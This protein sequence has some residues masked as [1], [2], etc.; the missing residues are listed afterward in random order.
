MPAVAKVTHNIRMLILD[1]QPKDKEKEKEIT[2][3]QP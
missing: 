2:L 1:M 3:Y